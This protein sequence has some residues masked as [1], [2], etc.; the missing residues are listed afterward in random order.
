MS[1]RTAPC[2]APATVPGRAPS[3]RAPVLSLL[4]CAAL[5]ACGGGGG[6]G[7]TTAAGTETAQTIPNTPSPPDTGPQA[8]VLEAFTASEQAFHFQVTD[9]LGSDTALQTAAGGSTFSAWNPTG[10][11]Q[12]F[13][14]GLKVNFF[15][16]GNGCDTGASNGP[17]GQGA[18]VA[19]P[20]VATA[21]GVSTTASKL[22]RW[23]PSGGFSPCSA[24]AQGR[25]GPNMVM[26]NPKSEAGGGVALYTHTGPDTDGVT[27]L[28]RPFDAS[29]QNGAGANADINGT[30]VTF[31]QDW[32]GAPRHPWLGAGPSLPSARIVTTQSVAAL[33]V[34]TEVIANQ[35]VQAK[36]QLSVGF[37]NPTCMSGGASAARPCQVSYLFNTAIQRAGIDDWSTV[38]WF[39]NGKV[40]FDPAQGGTPIIESPVK[41]AGVTVVDESSGLGLVQSKGNA[42][43]Y[44]AF[45]DFNFDLRISFDQLQNA[46]RIVAGRKY[47]VAPSAVSDAQMVELW[48]ATW[49]DRADW[50]LLAATSGQEV[51]NPIGTRQALIGGNFKQVYVGPQS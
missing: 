18:D 49:Q 32:L 22:W 14:A 31:R 12:L 45:S 51:H 4:M 37:V 8:V 27:S 33:E 19:L 38:S 42:T 2:P 44:G 34:G 16:R 40:W 43:Q 10:S 1:L 21:T 6:G 15:G 41:A 35:P 20:T 29:G 26:L 30:F 3:L 28:L 11:S 50:V 13:A 17:V 24:D 23:A 7:G 48:G 5:A 47:G 25:Q 36:Q 9:G 39:Q 46:L